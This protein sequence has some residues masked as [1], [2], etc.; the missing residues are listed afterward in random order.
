MPRHDDLNDLLPHGDANDPQG[1]LHLR[2]QYLE[3]MQVKN[4]SERTLENRR[5]Y[6]G[7]FIGWSEQRGLTKP[8]EITKPI[9]ERYQRFLFLYRKTNG[10]PLT[11]RTQFG[12]LVALR[13]WFKWLA[14][15]NHLLYNPASELELPKLEQRLPKYILTAQEA[16]LIINLAEVDTPLGIRDRAIMETLYSTGVRRMEL[17][18][19]SMYDIDAQRGTMKVRQGKGQKDR[20]IPIGDRALAWVQRYLLE[21]RPGLLVGEQAGDILFLT[22]HGEP[23]SGERLSQ[24]VRGY[25]DAAQVGK[26]GSCHLFRHTMATLMLENGCDIRFIQAMLGHRNLTTTQV[27]TLVSVRV[28]KDMHTAT[29]PA[30]V[31]REEDDDKTL[32]V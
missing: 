16:D 3:A 26:T 6:I 22:H 8:S 24:L 5:R 29:H 7:Y 30:K 14:K 1:M 20:V 13:S 11:F 23:F 15:S 27:Y 18:H 17:A 19:L 2:E 21:V 25:V 10:D 4:F 32:D 31:K 28:L 9:L 12:Y